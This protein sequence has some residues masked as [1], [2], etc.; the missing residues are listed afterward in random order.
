MD[1]E[2][3][4][5]IIFTGIAALGGIGAVVAVFRLGPERR[6]LEA[7]AAVVVSGAA[8][9]LLVPLR[10]E[11]DRLQGEVLNLRG[12]VATLSRDLTTAH[13]LLTTNGIQF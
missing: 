3:I 11:V 12:Q 7:D 10:E 2:Q 13:N 4:A 1:A 8:V 5:T 6:K 9:T